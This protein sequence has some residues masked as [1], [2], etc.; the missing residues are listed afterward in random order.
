MSN[1]RLRQ[2]VP[3]RLPGEERGYE[4]PVVPSFDA[5]E[6]KVTFAFVPIA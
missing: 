5:T 6:L 4:E 2:A 1:S 3:Q